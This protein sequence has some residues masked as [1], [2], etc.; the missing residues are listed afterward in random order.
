MSGAT[1]TMSGSSP[2]TRGA[3]GV[4]GNL[5]SGNRIIPAYAGSTTTATSTSSTAW[6]HPRIRGEHAPSPR[7]SKARCG[8][9]PHTRGAPA[10]WRVSSQMRRIIPAYAGSTMMIVHAHSVPRDHPRIR[11][12]HP[13]ARDVP[14]PHVGSSPHTRGARSRSGASAAGTGDHPRIRGEH[15]VAFDRDVHA[16]GSSPHTRGA[17]GTVDSRRLAGRIIPAYAGSTERVPSDPEN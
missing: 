14:L 7:S 2:H 10:A 15:D 6:D 8:S 9:S 17:Q 5:L 4:V 1:C 3:L 11:G 13:W 12:E 16:H